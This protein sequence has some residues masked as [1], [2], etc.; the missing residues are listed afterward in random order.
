MELPKYDAGK[1]DDW[2]K[3]VHAERLIAMLE[4]ISEQDINV[5]CPGQEGFLF[6]VGN[7]WAINSHSIPYDFDTIA[8]PINICQICRGFV[9]LPIH[10]GCPCR[11]FE[12]KCREAIKQTWIALEEKGYI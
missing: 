11:M 3:R 8:L 5:S 12:G 6:I 7:K 1:D 10:K 9:G 4:M 2:N